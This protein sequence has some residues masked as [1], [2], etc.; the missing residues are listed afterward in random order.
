MGGPKAQA[1]KELGYSMRKEIEVKAKADNLEELASKLESLGCAIA[2]PVR[3]NDAIFAD[4]K[5][6]A[7]E[8]F[9]PNKNL[10]RIRESNGKFFFTIKQPKAN[11]MDSIEYETEISNPEGMKE[12]LLLMGYQEVI[13]VHKTRRKT[14]H[15]GWEICLDEIDGLGSFVEVE[16]ITDEA[17]AEKV[18]N[19]L[20]AFLEGL[21]VKREDRIFDGYDTLLYLKSK[22]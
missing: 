16:K 13:Q 20:F 14:N 1:G 2:P 6:G 18:Q 7:F 3:Q 10:L 21:G 11:Q 4:A 8:E 15:N 19:E 22:E 12:T 17:D 9:Q 5:Y